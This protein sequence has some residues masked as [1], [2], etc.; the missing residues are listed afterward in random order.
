MSTRSEPSRQAAAAAGAGG[1]PVRVGHL[2]PGSK[3]GA[4]LVDFPGNSAGPLAARSLLALDEAALGEAVAS[5]QPI[6]LVFENE[7]PRLPIVVGVLPRDPGAALLGT[8]LQA[9]AAA[10]S[11][12]KKVEARVDG[13]RVVIEGDH[14]VVLRCGDASITLRRDGKLV[15]RGAYIETTSKGLNRIRGGSVKIN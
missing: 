2:A 4:L 7:D 6:V 8:L 1:A 12:G 15:L 11:P 9:P 3:V 5:R 10:A 14:E 13:K